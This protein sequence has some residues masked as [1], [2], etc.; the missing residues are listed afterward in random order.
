M[1]DLSCDSLVSDIKIF[2][3]DFK[4]QNSDEYKA[5]V[6]RYKAEHPSAN[7]SHLRKNE[8]C[9]FLAK[10][11]GQTQ[12]RST[13]ASPKKKVSSEKKEKKVV[14]F[15]N[16]L[17]RGPSPKKA[18]KSKSPK[19]I[20]KKPKSPKEKALEKKAVQIEKELEQVASP[21][22]LKEAKEDAKAINQAIKETPS[23]VGRASLKVAE[24]KTSASPRRRT[25]ELDEKERE[26][27]AQIKGLVQSRH[28]LLNAVEK[29][30]KEKDNLTKQLGPVGYRSDIK[31]LLKSGEIQQTIDGM[32]SSISVLT[33]TYKE[34]SKN[35]PSGYTLSLEA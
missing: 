14:S 6:K 35:L 11:L 32:I 15:K 33:K 16:T 1:T 24:G 9:T 3:K 12:F 27:V 19:K 25:S 28:D 22:K 8:L 4:S 23:L 26:L 29:A 17:T 20:L 21:R 7:V 31:L 34:L 2:V 18:R 10:Y 5:A 30:Q 13:K